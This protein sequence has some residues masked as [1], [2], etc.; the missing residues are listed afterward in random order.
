MPPRSA[1]AWLL[2]AS[3][4]FWLSWLLMPG[5]GVTDTAQIFALVGAHRASVRLS[6]VLQLVS[7]AAYAPGLAGVLGSEW[8]RGSAGVRLGCV[9]LLVGAMGSA[10]DA[11]LH[12]VAYE[13]TAPGV[14]AEAMAPVMRRLQ[15]PDLAFLLPF[16]AAFFAG[17]AVLVGA[18]RRRSPLARLGFASLLLAPLVA[19]AGAPATRAGLLA[20]RGVGLAVLA[21][22]AGSVGALGA[23]FLARSDARAAPYSEAGGDEP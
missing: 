22:L 4:A 15:G 13:M 17:H 11:I 23:S 21:A 2:V 8:G 1:G 3:L 18:L 20:P 7:A 6:V 10:A 9:L 14:P 19:A 12:L 5:V 16:V